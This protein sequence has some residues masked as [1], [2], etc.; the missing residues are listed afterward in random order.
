MFSIAIRN[1]YLKTQMHE[2][3]ESWRKLNICEADY[4]T[5]IKNNSPVIPLSNQ[6]RSIQDQAK[7]SRVAAECP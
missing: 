3:S 4:F 2:V 7:A 5:N 1:P 6:K